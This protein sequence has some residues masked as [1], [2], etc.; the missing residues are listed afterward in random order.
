MHHPLLGA[1]GFRLH[2]RRGRECFGRVRRGDAFADLPADDR[3]A[4]RSNA[5]AIATRLGLQPDVVQQAQR[6][7]NPTEVHV[8]NLLEQ[9]RHERTQASEGRSA[10]EHTRRQA[11]ATRRDLERQLRDV[12]RLKQ[13]ALVEARAQAEDELAELRNLINQVRVESESNAVT[14][15]WVRQQAQQIENAQRELRARN[16]RKPPA[17]QGQTPGSPAPAAAPPAPLRPGDRVYVP[18][19]DAEGD[20]S[21]RPMRR[22]VPRSNLAPSNC[23]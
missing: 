23:A 18:T 4:G 2:D 1:E 11:E 5:L 9:I 12:D 15:E 10:A 21:P 14:R 20:V 7:I 19:L 6:F 17:A 8:E 13:Q 3:L 22:T 16:R